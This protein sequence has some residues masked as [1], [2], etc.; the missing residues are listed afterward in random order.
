MNGN[1][2][3]AN[4][5]SVLIIVILIVTAT[6][7]ISSSQWKNLFICSLAIASIIFVF[8]IEY[9]FKGKKI[10]IPPS[11]VL[12]T[13]LFIFCALFLGEILGFYILFWWWD[14]LLHFIAGVYLTIIPLY[15]MQDI[16][17]KNPLITKKRF[18]TLTI[19]FAFSFS[20][21]F[22]VLWEE[23]EFIGDYFFITTMVK[24]GLE[25]TMTDLLI[26]TLGAFITSIIY[27]FKNLKL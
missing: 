7:S 4:K 17:S 8:I 15:L 13:I 16:V 25:D 1:H 24:G 14:L 21:T 6:L 10:L 22:G 19:I 2:K 18:T 20:I 5:I 23:F 11:F 26:K 12:I 27:Y 3:I 9:F